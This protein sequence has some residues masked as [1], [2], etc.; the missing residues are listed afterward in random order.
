MRI[1]YTSLSRRNIIELNRTEREITGTPGFSLLAQPMTVA[2]IQDLGWDRPGIKS[3][4]CEGLLSLVRA[5]SYL[6]SG[7]NNSD[8]LTGVV[9]RLKLRNAC[10]PSAQPLAHGGYLGHCSCFCVRFCRL[11]LAPAMHQ[12]CMCSGNLLPPCS[13]FCPLVFA[14]GG[15]TETHICSC[16]PLRPKA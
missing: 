4:L 2:Y 11:Q 10:K 5:I 8:R 15:F 9:V 1:L 16:P 13:R 3:R 7:Y 6:F 14:S 12:E